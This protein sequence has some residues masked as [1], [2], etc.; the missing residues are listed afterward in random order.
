MGTVVN[1]NKINNFYISG[2][3]INGFAKNGQVVFKKEQ[4]GDITPPTINMIRVQNYYNPNK[5]QN[6]ARIGD[7]IVVNMATS[8]ALKHN[9]TLV[10]GGKEFEFPLQQAQYNVYSKYVVLTE[11]MNL[12]EGEKIPVTVKGLEDLAGN[13]GQEITSTGDNNYYV[14]LDNIKPAYDK[15]Q[16]YNKDDISQTFISNGNIIRVLATFKEE[17][18][19]KP[20]LTI[21]NQ[22]AELNK[23]SDDS[24]IYQVD[25][26]LNGDNLLEEGILKFKISDYKDNAGNVGDDLT[27]ENA[28]NSL[29]YKLPTDRTPPTITVKTGSNETIGNETEGYTKI[30]FKIYDN[31]ALLEYDIN[32]VSNKVSASQWG[33]INNVTLQTKGV[34]VGENSLKVRDTT[35]NE[36]IMKFKIVES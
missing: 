31:V 21:G 28:S 9:P 5:N 26:P 10:L 29:T 16:I 17:L 20:I 12:V 30:S 34:V 1:G 2:N 11:D 33:D 22:T 13:I 8:E 6:Y 18:A 4:S 3:K 7:N 35:R 23:I 15:I 14:I 25:L 32:G 36:T 27:E 19:N 24:N